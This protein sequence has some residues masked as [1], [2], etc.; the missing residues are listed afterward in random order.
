M[1]SLVSGDPVSCGSSLIVI[2]A[3]CFD[4]GP[5]VL[6]RHELH[7]VQTFVS[8]PTLND[9][10]CRFPWVF[11]PDE[12]ELYAASPSPVLERLEDSEP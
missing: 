1:N 4:L 3:P 8:Q 6:E 11:L 9:S 7:D 10:M 12:V 2:H 5:R